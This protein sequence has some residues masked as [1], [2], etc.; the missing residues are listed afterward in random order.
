MWTAWVQGWCAHPPGLLRAAPNSTR[1][2][3]VIGNR[4]RTG[5]RKLKAIFYKSTRLSRFNIYIYIK[6]T[7]L[8]SLKLDSVHPFPLQPWVIYGHKQMLFVSSYEA[9]LPSS[10]VGVAP[11]QDRQLVLAKS[12][13][14]PNINACPPQWE[15]NR[16]MKKNVLERIEVASA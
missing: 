15:L 11:A 14:C 13:Y 6:P 16:V 12:L 10:Q 3:D 1:W 9:P 7:G 2:D 4:S 5:A 8:P